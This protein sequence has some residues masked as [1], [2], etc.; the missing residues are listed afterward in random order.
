MRIF[1]D[2]IAS[3]LSGRLKRMSDYV[4]NEF[5]LQFE[6]GIHLRQALTDGSRLYFEKNVQS[7]WPDRSKS[8]FTK[9]EI[10]LCVLGDGIPECAIELKYPRN[11]MYP[12]E[13]FKFIE[14]VKFLEELKGAGFKECYAVCLVEDP[15]FNNLDGRTRTIEGIYAPFRNSGLISG[16]VEKPTGK[17][18]HSLSLSG[19]YKVDWHETGDG[20][21]Y[22]IIA[23]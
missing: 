11:G 18:R 4:Y 23:V 14:D 5:S 6:L 1:Q 7:I 19:S 10:D 12:E 8:T 21:W 3:F 9:K 13:M 16:T 15:A 17:V 2:E 22:Y 20:R